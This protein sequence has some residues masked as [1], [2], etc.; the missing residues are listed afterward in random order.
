MPA[1]A[2]LPHA[3]R[4]HCLSTAQNS[5]LQYLT[6]SEN[7]DFGQKNVR[8]YGKIYRRFCAKQKNISEIQS[9]MP[10]EHALS[11]PPEHAACLNNAPRSMNN[12]NP[13]SHKLIAICAGFF[14]KLA[15]SFFDCR[16][17]HQIRLSCAKIVIH[18][19]RRRNIPLRL[20]QKPD[21]HVIE[22][23]F[24]ICLVLLEFR[25]DNTFAR[26]R[27]DQ[28]VIILE[29]QRILLHRLFE[30]FRGKPRIPDFNIRFPQI[31][32]INRRRLRVGV[33][34]Y[35]NLKFLYRPVIIAFAN[36]IESDVVM[37]ISVIHGI[38]A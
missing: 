33:Q 34:I 6:I 18:G 5:T 31:V 26:I 35:R 10:P 2:K 30:A 28:I 38:N 23:T 37:S 36:I 29:I 13:E 3:L 4:L 12:P 16:S 27:V 24:P 32:I 14:G 20:V 15:N 17:Y 21:Y 8:F 11:M 9:C 25:T 19:H 1:A 7:E 22:V